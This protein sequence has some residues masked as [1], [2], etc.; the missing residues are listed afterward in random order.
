MTNNIAKQLTETISK[1]VHGANVYE[2]ER[3][4]VAVMSCGICTACNNTD[5]VQHA[6]ETVIELLRCQVEIDY[7]KIRAM[8]ASGETNIMTL[9]TQKM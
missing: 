4:L 3:A 9:P 6:L 7:P 8:M 1:V 5:E 2:S